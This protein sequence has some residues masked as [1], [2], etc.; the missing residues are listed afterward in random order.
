MQRQQKLGA[1]A[2]ARDLVRSIEDMV[3][4]SLILARQNSAKLVRL[5]MS[6][7]SVKAEIADDSKSLN[8]RLSP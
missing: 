8:A 1:G 4:E 3:S 5:V 7:D 2:S 6:N